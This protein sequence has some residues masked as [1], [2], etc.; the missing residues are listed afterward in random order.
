LFDNMNFLYNEQEAKFKVLYDKIEEELN[1]WATSVVLAKVFNDKVKEY[2]KSSFSLFCFFL[3]VIGVLIVMI[4]LKIPNLENNWEN[5]LIYFILNLPFFALSIWL[6][7]FI[8]NRRAEAK[9]LEE[10]YKH[11]EV[12]AQS[13]IGYKK[14]IEELDWED[15]ELL[16]QHMWNLLNTISQDTSSFLCNKW[17]NHPF[18]DVFWNLF[19]KDNFPSWEIDMPWVWKVMFDNKK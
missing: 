7:V 4:Y 13:F 16:K 12:M 17:E 3:I 11:K 5:L 2:K 1:A 19:S 8:W 15:K 9:K 6:L 14:S 10:W 18:L